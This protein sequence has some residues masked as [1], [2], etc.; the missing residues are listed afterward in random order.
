MI[1]DGWKIVQP[2]VGCWGGFFGE[3]ISLA[4]RTQS[5]SEDKINVFPS[6]IGVSALQS[7]EMMTANRS[8]F[9]WRGVFPV[10]AAKQQNLERKIRLES[11]LITRA[12]SR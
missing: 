8:H 12:G 9:R 5:V 10:S 2:L 1:L 4:V 11:G 6:I 3:I 7:V